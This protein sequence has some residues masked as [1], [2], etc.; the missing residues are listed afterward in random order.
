M[1]NTESWNGSSWTSGSN[2]PTSGWAWGYAGTSTWDGTNWISAPSLST[3]RASVQGGAG[4]STSAIQMGGNIPP[5]SYS[6]AS[7]EFSPGSTALNV[8]TLTQS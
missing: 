2:V 3:G 6:N 4:T 7:E 5:G 8:R 1:N